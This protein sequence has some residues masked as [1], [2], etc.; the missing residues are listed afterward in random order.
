MRS[1]L[2][3][4]GMV[5]FVVG[6][7]LCLFLFGPSLAAG[8][9]NAQVPDG[10][11][12][13]ATRGPVNPIIL[14][15]AQLG[16]A[17]WQIPPGHDAT[18][19]IQAYADATSVSPE[20]K[21]TFYVSTQQAGTP[22]T[23]DIYRL[24]WY[25]GAGGRLMTQVEGQVGQAQG[26][27]DA[28][29]HHLVACSS[30][31]SDPRTQ[32]LEARWQPSYTLAVPANWTTGIYLAKFSDSHGWQTYVPF[33]VLGNFNS[34]YLAVTPDTT[35]AA[36]N[37]WGGNSLYDSDNG[38]LG[39]TSVK[40]RG[41]KV[42]FDRPYTQE[43]G[44]SQVLVFEADA[45]HWMER[46]GYDLSYISDLDMQ[47]D[48]RQLLHHKAYVSL[49]HDEYWTKEMRDG[50]QKAR[51]RGVGLAFLGA[52]TAYWQM[53]FEPNSKG[54]PNRT[55][56]CYKV[57]SDKQDLQSDPFYSVDNTRVTSQWRDPV[58]NRPENALVGIMYSDLTHQRIGY[59]WKVVQ[60]DPVL[61][62]ETS[63]LVNQE[64][65]CG[66]VGYEWDR[67]FNNG[68]TPEGLHV[69]ATS[70]TKNDTGVSDIS[71]TSYYIASSGAMVFA[72]GSIYWTT[73]LD[74]YRLHEDKICG[75]KNTT[76]NELQA[77]MANV[78]SSLITSHY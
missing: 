29:N 1:R 56:V 74:Y 15:N 32:L 30:C 44:S 43:D 36:Y 63:L 42:S 65:G 41:T 28:D 33:D 17:G 47:T 31:L 51:D 40:P 76:V 21:L 16:T 53:R 52:N 22:Y 66:L 45:I 78:M 50:V 54:V 2:V 25:A 64:Y 49:G 37:D 14:E 58:V 35:Y 26:Y 5:F 77:L 34:L 20:K 48:T 8:L 59:S 18:T 61:F 13:T 68:A 10:V 46:Q 6:L 69:I 67:V 19:Q 27:Y 12:A 73:A 9:N 24:G 7:V 60:T 62:K 71:N 11:L 38:T 4:G 3:V 72:T 23:I 55:V 75:N 39:E 57:A 70:A